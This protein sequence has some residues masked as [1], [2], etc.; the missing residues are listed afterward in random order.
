ME[1]RCKAMRSPTIDLFFRWIETRMQ[2]KTASR[3]ARQ[4]LA[5]RRTRWI[6]RN[7]FPAYIPPFPTPFPRRHIRTLPELIKIKQVGFFIQ[8]ILSCDSMCRNVVSSLRR[9][10][11][12]YVARNKGYRLNVFVESIASSLSERSSGEGRTK[13]P[14]TCRDIATEN[15]RVQQGFIPT[16]S[17]VQGNTQHS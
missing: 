10:K 2:R 1:F 4:A 11:Q 3:S 7:Q 16:P 15:R 5:G 6:I 13:K 17:Q 8:N 12:R 14:P 9:I